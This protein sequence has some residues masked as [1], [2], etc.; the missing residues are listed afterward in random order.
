MKEKTPSEVLNFLKSEMLK[1]GIDLDAMANEGIKRA[2][3]EIDEILKL[4]AKK[5]KE[6]NL[7]HVDT[8]K[9]FGGVFTEIL[10]EGDEMCLAAYLGV[11]AA[12]EVKRLQDA[13]STSLSA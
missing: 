2:D 10:M 6:K 5:V 11:L 7:S 3:A 13:E 12:R 8:I 1:S 9:M 4:A